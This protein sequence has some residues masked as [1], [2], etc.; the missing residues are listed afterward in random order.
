MDGFGKQKREGKGI[1]ENEG[2]R[3]NAKVKVKK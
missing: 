2:M 1:R 3:Q